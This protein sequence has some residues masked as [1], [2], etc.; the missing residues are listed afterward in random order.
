MVVR[1]MVL[2]VLL[3]G[4]TAL[5]PTSEAVRATDAPATVRVAE[6]EVAPS[7]RELVM[8]SV[9]AASQRG[10]VS[11]TVGGRVRE[12]RVEIGARIAAGDVLAVLETRG[13]ELARDAA[14]SQVEQLVA[15][16]EQL[17]A[18]TARLSNLVPGQSVSESELQRSR[19][20]LRSAESALRAAV[21]QAGEAERQRGEAILIAPFAGV[22]TAV[23][24]REGETVAPGQPL[25]QLVGE[26]A[27]EVS[28]QLPERVWAT[29][30]PGDPVVVELDGVGRRVTGHVRDVASAGGPSGLFP[31]IVALDEPVP[32]GLT[33]RV[34]LSVPLEAQHVVPMSAVVDPSGAAP[35]VFRWVDGR[36]ERVPVTLRA[37]VGDVAAIDSALQ[38]R[39]LVV[40]A[41]QARLLPGDAVEVLP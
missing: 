2:S 34:R 11:F 22:V 17:R 41:G 7:H 19:T 40:V 30:Q 29:A 33:A 1:S 12:R 16:V 3:A 14:A 15:Q 37:L 35:T 28:L 6:V 8:H 36:V 26:G 23:F 4:C 25:V 38:A 9:T 18:D 10:P 24:A 39:D 31:V 20:Q 21:A 13:F 27:S 5:L 32:A